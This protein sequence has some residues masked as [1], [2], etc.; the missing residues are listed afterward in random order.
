[1]IDDTLINFIA[2]KVIQYAKDHPK[3]VVKKPKECIAEIERIILE[4]VKRDEIQK[5]NT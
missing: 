1:M 2:H 4:E 3:I 5:N